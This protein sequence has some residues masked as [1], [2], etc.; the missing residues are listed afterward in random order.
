MGEAQEEP[1]KNPKLAKPTEGRGWGD[2]M[3]GL[4]LSI[5]NIALPDFFG[6]IKKVIAAALGVM[7]IFFVMFLI[8]ASK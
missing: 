1:N 6:L 7:A 2:S 4:G 5:P 8:L 3:S